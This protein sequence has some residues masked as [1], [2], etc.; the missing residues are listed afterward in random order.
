MT[1]GTPS[2]VVTS[3]EPTTDP[4]E[5][6]RLYSFHLKSHLGLKTF[7]ERLRFIAATRASQQVIEPFNY[8]DY[9]P[10]Q[11]TLDEA[12]LFPEFYFHFF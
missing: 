5:P 11:L 9:V 4:M 12:N 3:T 8:K 2:E 10:Y 7:N 1:Q 6:F